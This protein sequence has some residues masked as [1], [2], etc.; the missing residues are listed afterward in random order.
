MARVK[1][2][3]YEMETPEITP[4]EELVSIENEVEKVANK[5]I[6]DT[7]T[8]ETANSNPGSLKRNF[9]DNLKTMFTQSSATEAVIGSVI[10]S[11]FGG[12]EAGAAAFDIGRQL[13]QERIQNKAQQDLLNIRRQQQVRDDGAFQVYG[14]LV[15]TDGNQ[16]KVQKRTGKFFVGDKEI[17]ANQVLNLNIAEHQ[18]KLKSSKENLEQRKVQFEDKQDEDR[19]RKMEKPIK[20]Y[21][22]D[23]T[24]KAM[25]ESLLRAEGAK[26]AVQNDSVFALPATTRALARL[27]GEIGVLTDQDV[28]AWKGSQAALR[29]FSRWVKNAADGKMTEADKRDTLEMIGIYEQVARNRKQTKAREIAKRYAS[30]TKD[31]SEQQ[32]VD[33]LLGNNSSPSPQEDSNQE[34]PREVIRFIPKSQRNAVFDADTK[35]FIRWAD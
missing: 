22:S 7:L 4:L 27:S 21:E 11:A 8:Q 32:M 14:Y 16:V 1:G 18:R 13:G 30:T 26:L 23:P 17:P 35:Q 34:G 25:N 10:A 29:R 12:S 15:D 6:T 31:Y 5:G 19:T 24:V 3:L 20:A 28:G 33:I 2:K 9:L